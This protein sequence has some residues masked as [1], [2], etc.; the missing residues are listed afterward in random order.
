M[1]QEYVRPDK[2]QGHGWNTASTGF[3]RAVAGRA[4]GTSFTGIHHRETVAGLAVASAGCEPT[5]S[6][7]YLASCSRLALL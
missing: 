7:S 5:S 2:P 1:S 3:L 6:G 4:I